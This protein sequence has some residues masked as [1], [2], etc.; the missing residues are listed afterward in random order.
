M[1]FKAKCYANLGI[2][3]ASTGADFISITEACENDI[4]IK[5]E[6]GESPQLIVR[7]LNFYAT[8]LK[9][10][11]PFRACDIYLEVAN[12]KKSL[13]HGANEKEIKE[14]IASWATTL[15]NIGLLAKDLELYDLAYQF[16]CYANEYR[17]QTIDYH[18]KDYC[19]SI[20]VR[21]EL[22]LFV[23][24]EQDVNQ[25]INGIK[26]RV[27]LPNG[28]SETLSHTWYVCALYYYLGRDFPTAIRFVN[29]SVGASKKEGAIF[30]FRQDMRTKLLLGDIRA[31]QAKEDP[32]FRIE[33]ENIFKDIIEK[34]TGMYGNDSYYLIKPYMHLRAVTNRNDKVKYDIFLNSLIQHYKP[35]LQTYER[36]LDDYIKACLRK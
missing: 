24:K 35:R 20:N 17:F 36:K 31:D 34:I 12:I 32:A 16:V 10:I 13:I 22:E 29:K 1:L 26:S 2:A 30:D 6:Y 25:L 14:L 21:A 19:S 11:D 23:H 9:E 15:F 8:I 7:S 4:S 28:F 33:A 3:R 18:N 27:D 5:K